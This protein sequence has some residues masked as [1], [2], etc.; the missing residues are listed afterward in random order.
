M[1]A[2]REAIVNECKAV[3]AEWDGGG[4]IHTIDMGGMGPGYEQAIQTTAVEILRHLVDA[5]YDPAMWDDRDV[6]R[7][8][9]DAIDKAVNPRVEGLG[10]SGAQW[11]AAMNVATMF[12]MR[13]PAAAL[14]LAPENR[15]IMASAHFP[16]AAKQSA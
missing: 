11:G 4:L 9:R 2:A 7:A 14:A 6:W 13:G 8:D 5:G 3:V 16:Q 12:Y 10:L 15:R 1:D